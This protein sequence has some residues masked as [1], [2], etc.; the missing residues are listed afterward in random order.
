MARPPDFSRP[1]TLR[2]TQICD[3]GEVRST[4]EAVRE[5]LASQ[6]CDEAE[7]NACELALVEACNNA[8][9]YAQSAAGSAPIRVDCLCDA[10]RIEFR[11][12][13]HTPGFDWPK[14][15]ELPDPESESGRGIYLM[16]ALMD[17]SNY[18]RAGGENILTLT[19]HRT[20]APKTGDAAAQAD[21]VVNEL[22]E[23][24]SSSYESLS[25]IFR[26]STAQPNVGD[27]E[28]FARQ[29]MTDLLQITGADWFIL[30]LAP[31]GEA[32]LDVFVASDSGP[33]PAPLHVEGARAVTPSVE[34]QAAQARHVVWFDATHPLSPE[35]PLAVCH[36][37]SHGLV[38]PI[39]SAEN[40]IGTLALGRLT[41]EP[42]GLVFTAGQTNVVGTFAEFL[43]IQ[44]VNARFHE[45]RVASRLVAHELEIAN[46][47]QQSLLPRD[48]PAV[49]GFE[50]AATCRSAHQVGGDFYDVLRISEHELLLV[51]ADVMGKGVPAAMFAAILRTMVR[52]APELAHQPAALLGRVNRLL[53]DELS[54]VDMFITAQL[55][56][57][58][59]R[60]PRLTIA[61]A[62][63]CPLLV[64]S[65][66]GGGVRAFSPDGMP[67]GILKDT[68]FAEEPVPLPPEC[69]VL[70]YTDGLP[71]AL[72]SRG[73]R[74][75]QDR[76]LEWLAAAARGKTSAAAL[77]ESLTTALGQFQTSM[78]LN[79]DQTFLI[80]CG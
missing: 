30:R 8:V 60:L 62:G 66:G 75:G 50:L 35:D 47:I 9:K 12:H 44:V 59:S 80:M 41:P 74:F 52:A 77:Q 10:N 22:V 32:R 18:F 49:P 19:K 2:L 46:N 13:D 34:R 1:A 57:F 69:R 76:L 16:K 65:G 20:S 55:G 67:L 39:F 15:V 31:K 27:L 36:P 51:I 21:P 6:G 23:E 17:E 56:Y 4:A 61:S 33:S 64:A 48:L 24:L 72:D 29:L 68:T 3:L 14:H 43:A 37:G 63:H 58:N 7:L 28:E 79:D 25:A 78:V 42:N 70:F 38:H 73:Q 71:E 54:G 40:L 5:F 11:I 53:F 45:E 26:Y